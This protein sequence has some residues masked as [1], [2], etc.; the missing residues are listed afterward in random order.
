MTDAWVHSRVQGREKINASG[1]LYIDAVGVE[2]LFGAQA[3]N[4]CQGLR[5]G[6]AGAA[7]WWAAATAFPPR[8]FSPKIRFSPQ[9]GRSQA[10][11]PQQSVP[12]PAPDRSKRLV[13]TTT[14]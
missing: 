10:A 14:N 1:E 8:C 2:D 7:G 5:N 12:G 9:A 13:L 4:E 11:A 6:V 3:S